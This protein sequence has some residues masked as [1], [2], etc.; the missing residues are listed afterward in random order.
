LCKL[1]V[2]GSI[3]SGS[4]R[5]PTGIETYS[6]LNSSASLWGKMDRLREKQVCYQLRLVSE[7]HLHRK[8]G[9]CPSRCSMTCQ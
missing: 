4:T 8:E 5:D 6:A 3:P 9:I 2:V 7:D 1:Q